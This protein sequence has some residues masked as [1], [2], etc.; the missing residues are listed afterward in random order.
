MEQSSKKKINKEKVPL[1]DTVDQMELTDIVRTFHPK[2]G[3]YI[4]LQGHMEHSPE[5]T[6]N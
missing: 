3:D 1:N 4:F 2:T 6:M 5:K